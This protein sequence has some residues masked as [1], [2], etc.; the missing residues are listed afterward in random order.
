M[1]IWSVDDI[2]PQELEVRLN[3]YRWGSSEVDVDDIRPFLR[4]NMTSPSERGE[5]GG[6]S[7]SSSGVTINALHVAVKFE[8]RGVSVTLTRISEVR[9]PGN[10]LAYG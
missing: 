4:V 6:R 8:R 2:H 1:G 7:E 9:E 10:H 5:N 3:C